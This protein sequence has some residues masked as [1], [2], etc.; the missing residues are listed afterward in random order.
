MDLLKDLVSGAGCAPDGAAMAQNPLTG[1]MQHM[2]DSVPLPGLL[3]Q[4]SSGER[5]VHSHP[6]VSLCDRTH[7]LRA[8]SEQG[9]VMASGMGPQESAWEGKQPPAAV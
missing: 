2:M 8:G 9:F 5:L 3:R 4:R 6:V 7:P 1:M